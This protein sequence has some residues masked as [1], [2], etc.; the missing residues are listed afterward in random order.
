MQDGKI[1]LTKNEI[2]Y[3]EDL[4]KIVTILPG[5]I[6]QYIMSDKGDVT[7]TYVSEGVSA[8][9]GLEREEAYMLGRAALE[10]IHPAD[11]PDYRNNVLLSNAEGST[12]T[13]KFRVVH[14]DGTIKWVQATSSPTRLSN[15][16][17]LRSGFVIDVTETKLIESKIKIEDTEA[18]ELYH[19]VNLKNQQFAKSRT[20]II[21]VLDM[22]P[23]GVFIKNKKG[24]FIYANN[25]YCKMM[26]Q[27]NLFSL[28]KHGWKHYLKNKANVQMIQ[29][30]DNYILDTQSAA[31]IKD[32]NFYD[33]NGSVRCF[34]VTKSIFYL[35]DNLEPDIIG[36]LHET[37]LQKQAEE[38]RKKHIEELTLRNKNLEQFSYIVSHNLRSPVSTI[39]GVTRWLDRTLNDLN[40]T[41]QS[42]I[43]GLSAAAKK[44]DGVIRDLNEILSLQGTKSY[45]HIVFDDILQD[46]CGNLKDVIN[47]NDIEI[48][49]NF[50]ELSEIVSVQPYIHSI[51][52]NLISNSIK[53]RK[54]DRHTIIE[55]RTKKENDEIKLQFKDNGR[56]INM[57][58]HGHMLFELYKQFHGVNEGRGMGLYMVKSQVE[59]LKG[60]IHVASIEGE[61]TIITVILNKI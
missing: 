58:A 8:L 45:E 14:K 11:M 33:N 56:G 20:N 51:F 3:V 32:V 28:Q 29:K 48:I 38:E 39:L 16:N 47:N 44:V 22:L 30:Q 46:V 52:Y 55:V 40:S 26:G 1:N 10:R 17:I 42:L 13:Q 27:D 4:K 9:W 7:F 57:K 59:L 41:T 36:I 19:Q 2:E 60:T 6:F 21:T 61:G 31:T 12:I 43:D 54:K 37:T 50:M 53:Y 25:F 34:D 15:G 18:S 23:M 24:R 5:I 49:G 35:S